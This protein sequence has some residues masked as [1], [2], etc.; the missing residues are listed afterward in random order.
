MDN[1]DLFG[2]HSAQQ[3]SNPPARGVA[4]LLGTRGTVLEIGTDAIGVE[5]EPNG[6]GWLSGAG[7]VVP[8]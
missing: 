6:R 8:W 5:R 3:A 2:V 4:W 1:R 7:C